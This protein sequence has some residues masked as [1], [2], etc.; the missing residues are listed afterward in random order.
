MLFEA[1]ISFFGFGKADN[2]AINVYY[3]QDYTQPDEENA[4]TAYS[5]DSVTGEKDSTGNGQVNFTVIPD[6]GCAVKSIAAD[7]EYKNIKDVSDI[8]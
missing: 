6:E 5:R 8:A 7:G 3:K 1:I 4:K 2:A